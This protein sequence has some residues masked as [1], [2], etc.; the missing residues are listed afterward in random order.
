M[1]R[2]DVVPT[3]TTKI[4]IIIMIII[5]IIKITAT[6]LTK[7]KQLTLL[8]YQKRDEKQKKNTQKFGFRVAFQTGPDFKNI[9]CKNKDKLIPNSYPGVY[10]LK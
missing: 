8:G 6:T 5:I 2:N 9:L 7:S 3:T 1:K 4:I 10:E